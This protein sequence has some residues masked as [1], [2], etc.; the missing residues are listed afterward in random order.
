ML[1]IIYKYKSINWQ[2]CNIELFKLQNEILKAY[3]IGTKK[4]DMEKRYFIFI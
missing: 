4:S 3:R 1:K 2:Q